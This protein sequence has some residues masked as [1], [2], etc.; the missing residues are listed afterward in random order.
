M[1]FTDRRIYNKLKKL[2]DNKYEI[3]KLK[4]ISQ[5]DIGLIRSILNINNNMEN[6]ILFKEKY[7]KGRIYIHCN[8][9]NSLTY[10]EC[11]N[12]LLGNEVIKLKL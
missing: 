1:E 8:L 12:I 11:F 10:N 6:F 3:K 5:D 2:L 7:K 9:K 4:D